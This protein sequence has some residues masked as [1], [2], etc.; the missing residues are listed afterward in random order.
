MGKQKGI[1]LEFKK[2]AKITQQKGRRIPLQLQEAVEKEIDKLLK[3]DHIRKLE[4]IIDDIFIQT[5]II[6]IKEDKS[7]KMALDARSLNDAIRND[8]YQ[9]PNHKRRK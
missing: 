1:K 9:K 2:D 7:V 3:E 4:K 5:V 6:T 8:K